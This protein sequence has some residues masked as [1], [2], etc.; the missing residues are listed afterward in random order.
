M[1]I[2]IWSSLLIP[3]FFGQACSHQHMAKFVLEEEKSIAI[4]PA[5]DPE[6]GGGIFSSPR[7]RDIAIKAT[8]ALAIELKGNKIVEPTDYLEQFNRLERDI[9][10][11][12]LRDLVN[13]P[14][15]SEFTDQQIA[16]KIDNVH[17]VVF[18][19][20][21]EDGWRTRPPGSVNLL[22]G[23]SRITVKVY[24]NR[25]L[26]L[27]L[28]GAERV[29]GRYPTS[30]Y[31]RDGVTSFDGNAETIEV[32]LIANTARKIALLFVDHDDED[33]YSITMR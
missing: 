21:E 29:Q 11:K 12:S 31:E 7:G 26:K 6:F 8:Q 14:D 24:D 33:S 10:D 16:D 23:N 20:I 27:R 17:Y 3:V 32:G 2:I 18:L 5:R 30:Y 9:L 25:G 15:P 28:L 19:Q 1:R 22:R 4:L 13:S